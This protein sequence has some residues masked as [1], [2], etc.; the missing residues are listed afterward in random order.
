MA[1]VAKMGSQVAR[2]R[3]V[4]WLRGL[5]SR[6]PPFERR[7]LVTFFTFVITDSKKP[8]CRRDFFPTGH[9]FARATHSPRTRED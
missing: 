4:D 2:M 6:F 3:G 9:T 1:E 5:F 7:N 8:S